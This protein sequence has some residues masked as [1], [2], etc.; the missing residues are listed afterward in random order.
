MNVF[1]THSTHRKPCSSS[2]G[3]ATILII[4]RWSIALQGCSTCILEAG[5]PAKNPTN[6]APSTFPAAAKY[7]ADA[8]CG[9]APTAPTSVLVRLGQALTNLFECPILFFNTTFLDAP[10]AMPKKARS[11]P[12]PLELEHLKRQT[13]AGT[14][15]SS[16]PA[17]PKMQ[18]CA[19]R[20]QFVSLCCT[21]A[22]Q[23]LVDAD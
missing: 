13:P 18:A 16:L 5:L 10:V 19:G 2:Y 8:Y 9:L 20:I 1:V 4:H 21:I 3:C 14:A 12:L 11:L 6:E 23:F 7:F 22:Y 15:W 17:S